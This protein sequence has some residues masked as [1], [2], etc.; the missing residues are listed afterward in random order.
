ADLRL[1]KCPAELAN[2]STRTRPRKCKPRSPDLP[3][4]RTRTGCRH[5]RIDTE[6]EGSP[7]PAWTLRT[8]QSIHSRNAAVAHESQ[9]AVWQPVEPRTSTRTAIQLHT[10]AA[11]R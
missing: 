11:E 4:P 1:D 3:D 8:E 7:A 5:E 2:L 9:C 10:G 6:G